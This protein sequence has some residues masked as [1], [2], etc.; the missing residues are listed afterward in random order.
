[1]P[2]RRGPLVALAGLALVATGA[3]VVADVTTDV[4]GSV[5]LQT[6]LDLVGF[7]WAAA[8]ALVVRH[9][10][11]HTLGWVLLVVGALTQVSI[12]EEAFRR[13]GWVS[14]S[15]AGDV[16]T[17][18]V[19]SGI[20]VMLGLLPLL[21]P[22]GRLPSP[23]W[24]PLAAVVI[25]GAVAQMVQWL[26]SRLAGW[27]WPFDAGP[28]A[29]RLVDWVPFAVFAV[30]TL[31][32]WLLCGVRIARAGPP[33]RQQ[34]VL[35]LVAVMAPLVS[36]ALGDSGV[37][38]W[39]N[40]L[41]LM[42][43]P[44]A[45]AIGIFRYRMLG[46]ELVLRRGLVYAV[47]TACVVVA[48]AVVTWAGGALLGSE[49]VP[50]VLAAALLAVV[51]LPLR[52]AAQRLVD[53]LLYG[54][55][56]DPLSAVSALG[57][58]VAAAEPAALAQQLVAGVRE[59]VRARAVRI[60]RPDGSLV[61]T[62]GSV[63]DDPAEVRIAL[64]VGGS[65]VGLLVVGPRTPRTP[66]LRDEEKLFQALAPQVAVALHAMDMATELELQRDQVIAVR[67][68][69]RDR[70]RQDIHDGLGPSLTGIGLGLRAVDDAAVAADTSRV[71]E[72]TGVIQSEVARTVLDIRRILDDLRPAQVEERGLA[73]ALQN[74]F[75]DHHAPP[76]ITVTATALPLLPADIE[77]A[78]F[79]VA[80]EA[81]NNAL[82]HAGAHDVR[83]S[84]TTE[85]GSLVVEVADDGSGLPEDVTEGIGLASM[86]ARARAVGGV[87]EIRRGHGTA[88]RLAVPL[89]QRVLT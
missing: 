63:E 77:D 88:V 81:T 20:F 51:L 41:T 7:T 50:S 22:S 35:L 53:R 71:R 45:I 59:M 34:L 16:L 66:Y 48:Y 46:I 13:A 26:M 61:A 38:Q 82:R 58:V 42:L 6:W 25:V 67:A 40:A 57:S 36:S 21:Y 24:R 62:S 15:V 85:A 27:R 11:R 28:P 68:E 17:L 76:R 56:D 49:T 75:G 5:V 86:R 79:R 83:V 47:L 9:R 65:E 70:L 8:G 78:A 12:A 10:S 55:R 44:A 19:G 60:E 31:V 54:R 33:L 72:L 74:A 3:A 18:V 73:A 4:E 80:L 32:G 23:R 52:S 2:N 43:L 39:L 69:E 64:N 84:L 89:Q 87:V 29:T 1:M 30:G 14:D 37:A